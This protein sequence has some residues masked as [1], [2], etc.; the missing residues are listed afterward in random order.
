M[1][2]SLPDTSSG[3][4]LP[5]FG[6]GRLLPESLRTR[7]FAPAYYD[8]L[9][10]SRGSTGNPSL[11]GIK[12]LGLCLESLRVGVPN[13]VWQSRRARRNVLLALVVI[14]LIISAVMAS[15]YGYSQSVP[16]DPPVG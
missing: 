15:T 8:L 1:A 5:W 2:P 4:P 9:A 16:Y 12:V 3:N 14:L 7:V 6:L 13:L 11:L 10:E